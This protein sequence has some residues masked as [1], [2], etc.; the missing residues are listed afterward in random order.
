MYHISNDKRSRQ[1]AEL[2]YEGLLRCLERKAFDHV[3]VSDL[4]R[5]SGVARTTFYRSFDNTS[6]VLYWKCDLCFHEILGSFTQ[7]EFRNEAT[8]VFRY[9]EYW[10]EHADI[11]EL[12]L[13]INRQDVIYACHANAARAMAERFS[14]NGPPSEHANYFLAIRTGFTI[15]ILTAWLEEGRK[16]SPKE[17]VRI[18]REQFALIAREQP[19]PKR[20]IAAAVPDASM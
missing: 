16:E 13:R 10:T 2:V 5:E 19:D 7:E 8:L 11:L 12:L 17:V 4:Q 9:F 20:E 18:A 15:S 6:D 3:T 1:S 14:R